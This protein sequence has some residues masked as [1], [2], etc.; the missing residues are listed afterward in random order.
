MS[1]FVYWD[2]VLGSGKCTALVNFAEVAECVNWRF[3]D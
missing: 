1:F 2:G 3:S